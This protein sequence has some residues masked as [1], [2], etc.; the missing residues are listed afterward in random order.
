[1]SLINDAL[2]RA[3]QHQKDSPAPGPALAPVREKPADPQWR[4]MLGLFIFLLVAAAGGVIFFAL[5]SHPARATR[6]IPVPPVA[7]AM[8]MAAP[9]AMAPTPAPPP[10]AATSA[11]SAMVKPAPVPATPPP[12]AAVA[13]LP[14]PAGPRLQG[15]F[16]D[17]ANSTAIISGKTVRVG[18]SVAGYKVKAITPSTVVLLAPDQSETNLSLSE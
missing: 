1:M 15:I 3:R 12:A 14:R 9:A 17:A 10:V 16:Y 5:R 4:L 8:A 7:P 6:Q 11:P 2:K 13:A 18:N